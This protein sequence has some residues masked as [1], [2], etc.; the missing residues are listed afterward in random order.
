ML[1]LF[2][3]IPIT[4]YTKSYCYYCSKNNAPLPHLCSNSYL[5]L[6]PILSMHEF[7]SSGNLSIYRDCISCNNRT[8]HACVKCYYCYSCH[9]NIERLEKVQIKTKP[10][11]LRQ[12]IN[13]VQEIDR[14]HYKPLFI[15]Y[16]VK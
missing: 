6:I 1:N 7:L 5:H 12:G 2:Y 9:A 10:R 13:K 15:S 3:W 4:E 14:K 11:T 8:A 16:R